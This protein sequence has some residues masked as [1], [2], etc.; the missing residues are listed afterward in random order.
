[1]TLLQQL[2]LFLLLLLLS[3][4]V[5]G[6]ISDLRVARQTTSNRWLLLLPVVH[7]SAQIFAEDFVLG[8]DEIVVKK[9]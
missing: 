1:M 8:K 9:K 6:R 7:R 2:Q 5:E 4:I 3:L